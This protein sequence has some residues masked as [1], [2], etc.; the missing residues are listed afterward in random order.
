MATDKVSENK[1]LDEAFELL[2]AGKALKSDGKNWDAADKFVQ[3]RDILQDLAKEQPTSNDEEKQI[4]ELY[5]NQAR[6][7]L[8]QSRTCLIEAMKAEK[9]RDEE[10]LGKD[11]SSNLPHFSTLSDEEAET[12]IR[13]FYSLFSRRVD[14]KVSE[15]EETPDK[16]AADDVIDK[17]FSLEERLAELNKSLPSGF[18]TSDERMDDIN[19]GLNKLGISLYDQ[20]PMFW[21]L[22]DQV[23]KSEEDQVKEIMEQAK[24]EVEF[25]KKFGTGETATT[26]VTSKKQEEDDSE[27][28]DNDDEDDEDEEGDELL[29]DEALSIKKIRKKVINA[30]VKLAEL[31]A[32]LDEAKAAKGKE[33]E[34]RDLGNDDDSLDSGDGQHGGAT[35]YLTLGKKKLKGAKRDMQ[36]ALTE[37]TENLS[38]L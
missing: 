24:D 30:Q 21:R 16:D 1:K 18:K 17:Q 33:D 2:H 27:G 12:R 8:H 36:R 15:T 31:V 5:K 7:Y 19:R 13:T 25:E 4:S 38:S 35:A 14:Q 34:E 23:P 22:Q 9:E 3:A 6:E 20:K 29:D 10:L 37:W 11:D 32:L 28:S 26:G